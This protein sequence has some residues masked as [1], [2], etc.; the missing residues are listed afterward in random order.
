MQNNRRH[1]WHSRTF[2]IFTWHKL[3]SDNE[4]WSD[5]INDICDIFVDCFVKSINRFNNHYIR[6]IIYHVGIVVNVGTVR[7]RITIIII[8]RI[9]VNT[10]M[11][12]SAPYAFGGIAL[13]TIQNTTSIACSDITIET[14]N[15]KQL[16]VTLTIIALR[17][18]AFHWCKNLIFSDIRIRHCNNTNNYN[19]KVYV[20]FFFMNWLPHKFYRNQSLLYLQ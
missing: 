20:Y 15:M 4:K 14:P 19:K 18:I 17:L 11:T 10:S 9:V 2:S 1:V 8:V 12:V 3:H 13:W 5:G 16:K 6:F 7:T